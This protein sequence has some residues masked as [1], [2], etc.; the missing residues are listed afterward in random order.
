MTHHMAPSSQQ[1]LAEDAT[2]EMRA[3]PQPRRVALVKKGDSK[4]RP[5]DSFQR[6]LQ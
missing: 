4:E 2:L 1:M 3:E 5:S 6:L